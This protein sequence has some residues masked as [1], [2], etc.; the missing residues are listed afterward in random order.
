MC[1]CVC[2]HA[3]MRVHTP[4][5]MQHLKT[6][7]IFSFSKQKQYEPSRKASRTINKMQAL[8]WILNRCISMTS[9]WMIYKQHGIQ[10]LN[11]QMASPI[12]QNKIK[13]DVY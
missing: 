4:K 2:V 1:T 12:I 8:T 13:M 6:F 7:C 3:Q 9:Y 10:K 11:R 5:D